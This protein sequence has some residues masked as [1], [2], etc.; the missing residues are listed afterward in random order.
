MSRRDSKHSERFRGTTQYHDPPKRP[1]CL[2]CGKPMRIET[3]SKPRS[4]VGLPE[5]YD[6]VTS[7]YRCG[8]AGCPGTQEP[9]L[10]PGDPAAPPYGT[11]DYEVIAK[12][13]EL[14]WRHHRT[15]LEIVANFA[16]LFGITV[17]QGTVGDWLKIYEIGCDGKYRPGVV[18]QMKANGGVILEIDLMKPLNGKKGLY[19]ARDYRTSQSLGARKLPN[20]KH[21]TI[22]LFLAGI[23][24]SLEELGVPIAGIVS[25]AHTAQRIAV[26]VVFPGVPHCLCHFHFFNL[27]LKAPKE[28][29]SH[30]CTVVRA[31]LRKLLDLKKYKAGRVAGTPYVPDGS[32]AAEVLGALSALAN[33]VRRPKDPCL[34]GLEMYERVYDLSRVL[35]AAVESL[36][37]G[38]VAMP[39]EKVIRRLCAKVDTIM[40]EQAGVAAELGRV[41]GHLADLVPILDNL[42]TSP[43]EGLKQLRNLRD[44]IRNARLTPQCGDA[45]R[46]FAEEFMKFVRTKGE[47]LFNYKRVPGAPTTNNDQELF[48]KQLKHFLRRVVGHAAANVYLLAHGERMVFVNPAET[49]EGIVEI[50]RAV[51][52]PAAREKI[53]SERK[54]RDRMS[55]L[56]HIP[57]R[58]GERIKKMYQILE[59][60]KH[61]I[62]AIT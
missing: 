54:V 11:F 34:A 38:V 26:K 50:L 22:E 48:Y 61:L 59:D 43:E 45:E 31:A 42:E 33:W 28:L 16:E 55:L 21:E 30:L 19:T 2:H 13:C 10:I 53:S 36:E 24:A 9:L 60:L 4:L 40:N 5:D 27:V 6:D 29:D 3:R 1:P 41:R 15:I 37:A 57:E 14:R 47:L 17:S 58:W 51:D 18:E 7:Y 25:D 52:Y 46:K 20:Q 12:A 8:Q 39:E 23:K 62:P 49:F 32:L 56:M 35:Q 44:R